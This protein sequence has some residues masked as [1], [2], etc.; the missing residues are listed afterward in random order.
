MHV[1]IKRISWGIFLFLF[2]TSVA[3]AACPNGQWVTTCIN[4]ASLEFSTGEGSFYWNCAN[5]T[6]N[7]ISGTN[8]IYWAA[9]IDRSRVAPWTPICPDLSQGWCV[10][11]DA[12]SPPIGTCGAPNID[13]SNCW[14]NYG[15][16]LGFVA[17][18]TQAQEWK[19][20]CNASIDLC[21]NNPDPCCKTPDDPCCK[22]KDPK[23]CKD[24]ESCECK[25]KYKNKG[26]GGT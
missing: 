18:I 12:T 8:R 20:P 6:G 3:K 22:S 15:G 21:C 10:S 1:F 14:N 13:L 19:C 9:V 7:Y 4:N 17:V 16:P 11:L 24:P 5:K 2:F 23:C 26:S 25:D